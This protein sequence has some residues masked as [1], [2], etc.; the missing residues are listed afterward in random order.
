MGGIP[1]KDYH[2]IRGKPLPI[3]QDAAAIWN[4]LADYGEL[5]FYHVLVHG[6]RFGDQSFLRPA[7]IHYL[8]FPNYTKKILAIHTGEYIEMPIRRK[9]RLR[10]FDNQTEQRMW[11]YFRDRIGWT[12]NLGKQYPRLN[13]LLKDLYYLFQ[14]THERNEEMRKCIQRIMP[15]FN[16]CQVAIME[17]LNKYLPTINPANPPSPELVES[18]ALLDHVR[19][20]VSTKAMRKEKKT[21]L[22]KYPH[23]K[24]I[25]ARQR[26]K[27]TKKIMITREDV[28]VVSE[29]EV[30]GIVK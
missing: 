20:S 11:Y 27:T 24:V 29:D 15:K 23:I 5:P 7:L 16:Q 14:S 25:V 18:L 19:E 28:D 10:Y 6:F 26:I 21:L 4:E 30:R 1:I 13:E 3:D 12:V 2:G 9:I 8:E 22:E 17:F